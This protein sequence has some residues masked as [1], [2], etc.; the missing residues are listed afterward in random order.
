MHHFELLL[1]I[2][3]CFHQYTDRH[4]SFTVI[5]WIMPN[6]NS[7][8]WLFSKS[9]MRRTQFLNVKYA[10]QIRWKLPFHVRHHVLCWTTSYD[11]DSRPESEDFNEI[12]GFI[13]YAVDS[14]PEFTESADFLWIQWI[15]Q[16]H[17][18]LRWKE[19][20]HVEIHC[21][22]SHGLER[23]QLINGLE[24]SHFLDNSQWQIEIS[25]KKSFDLEIH[26]P[27]CKD[28]KV[29]FLKGV[30]WNNPM[31]LKEVNW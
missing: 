31:V 27:L 15:D 20:I 1:R 11:T 23:S 4:H 22:S 16:W 13:V 24:R 25:C 30:T 8:Q 18:K 6:L 26:W 29:M 10:L 9:S 5:L 12:C 14:K 28:C 17:D 19:S 3:V 7:N 2:T 21:V